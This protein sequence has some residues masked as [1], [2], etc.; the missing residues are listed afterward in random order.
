MLFVRDDRRRNGCFT[1]ADAHGFSATVVSVPYGTNEIDGNVISID[2]EISAVWFYLEA[3]PS[4]RQTFSPYQVVGTPDL[5]C[6]KL[7][8]SGFREHRI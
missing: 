3:D 2:D 5:I 7:L 8:S 1:V 4:K 6:E